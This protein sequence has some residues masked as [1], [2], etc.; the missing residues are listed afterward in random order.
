[1]RTIYIYYKSLPSQLQTPTQYPLAEYL[2]GKP[3]LPIPPLSSSTLIIGR[4]CCGLIPPLHKYSSINNSLVQVRLLVSILRW[5]CRVCRELE[6]TNV[7]L[8]LSGGIVCPWAD[9]L[10]EGVVAGRVVGPDFAVRWA[11]FSEVSK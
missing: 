5:V 1:M 10:S 6:D 3:P 11:R 9:D 4:L 2:C 7:G 8:A